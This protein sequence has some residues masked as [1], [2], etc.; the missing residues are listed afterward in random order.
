MQKEIDKMIA[1]QFGV[2]LD[3]EELNAEFESLMGELHGIPTPTSAVPATQAIAPV[4]AATVAVLQRLPDVPSHE[5]RLP[6]H[7]EGASEEPQA[8]E[9]SRIAVAS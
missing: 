9:N 1:S 8:P 7:I 4:E 3:D 6:E 2:V 5:I